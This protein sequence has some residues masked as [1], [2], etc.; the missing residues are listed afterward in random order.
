MAK[1]DAL[2]SN[3]TYRLIA[4][5]DDVEAFHELLAAYRRMFV[6]LTEVRI[7]NRVRANVV[8]LTRLAYERLRAETG[9]HARF[10]TLGIR[11]YA[12]QLEVAPEDVTGIPLDDKLFT[13]K[14]PSEVTIATLS[15]R[16][17]LAYR[18]EGY[19]TS[20]HEVSPARLIIAGDTLTLHAGVAV[21]AMAEEAKTMTETLL[22]R[23]GR[24]IAGY[25]SAA[26]DAVEARDPLVVGEEALR[27]ID[28]VIHE[29]R[30]SVGQIDAERYRVDQRQKQLRKES[31]DLN[32]KI[33]SAL[34]RDHEDL[35][36]TGIA[37]QIDIETQLTTL[38]ATLVEIDER[39]DTAREA[40]S[41]AL[42]A[43]RDAEHRVAL[44]RNPKPAKGEPVVYGQGAQAG[45]ER[46]RRLEGSLRAIDRVT[47][48]PTLKGGED[49]EALENLH[50]QSE[51][52]RRLADF[53]K[54]RPA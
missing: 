19:G 54:D 8:E 35:A 17:T 13:I 50:R 36:R 31:A 47:G 16:R 41:A 37:H 44:L 15:G 45:A 28:G 52:D 39:R 1:T 34:E 3:V 6:I 5:Q 29:A 14:G 53:K 30:T 25:S 4:Q 49:L 38:A 24:L 48:V 12:Q 51:I 21:P 2:P 32:A 40:L 27:E 9:L 7:E 43:R 33:A 46:E 22:T 20:W 42:A 23:V 11:D 26:L 18:V 10:I